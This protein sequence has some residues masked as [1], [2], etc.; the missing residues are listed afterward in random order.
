MPNLT[1]FYQQFTNDLSRANRFEVWIHTPPNVFPAGTFFSDKMRN[2]EYLAFRCESAQLPGRHLTTVNQKT[3]GPYEKFPVHTT[4]NDI[5]LTFIVDGSMVP[6]YIFD[7]W[8]EYIN[9]SGNFNISYKNDY[10]TDILINQYDLNDNLSYSVKLIDAF[11]I[12][13]NQQDLNWSSD[14]VHKLNV[15]FAYTYWQNQV[16]TDNNPLPPDNGQYNYVVDE[17][18]TP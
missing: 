3:F 6:R 8:I 2:G 18:Q 4:Y 17:T 16:L 13:I 7:T 10:V 15:T 11:P 14:S 1:Q 5:D 9:P 12:N